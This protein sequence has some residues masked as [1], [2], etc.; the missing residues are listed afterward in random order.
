MTRYGPLLLALVAMLL[1]GCGS[2]ARGTLPVP[3]TVEE[4][5]AGP[6]EA[7]CRAVAKQRADD[8]HANGYEFAVEE[9][10]YQETYD[11]CMA[12]RSRN[13]PD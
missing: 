11:D 6:D 12:W 4:Q 5:A 3:A 7:H 8:A 10:V 1:D 9:R 13:K 2:D